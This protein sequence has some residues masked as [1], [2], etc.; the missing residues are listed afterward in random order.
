MKRWPSLVR[1]IVWGVGGLAALI[2]LF[3]GGGVAVLQT[4]SGRRVLAN[5]VNAA[6]SG[7]GLAVSV[8]N[9]GAGLPARIAIGSVVVSDDQGPWVTLDQ[10]VIEWR[11]LTLL[12]GTVHLETIDVA[13]IDL[14]RLPAGSEPEEPAEAVPL[15]SLEI[16]TLPI[17]VRVDRIGMR[18]ITLAEAVAGE[19]MVLDLS[20]RV[21]AQEGKAVR[22]DL[23]LERT[24]AGGLVTLVSELD[25]AEQTL[26]VDFEANE[27]KGGLLARLL[28]LAP[29]PPV[30]VTVKGEGPLDAWRAN[31]DA[32]AEEL[33][34]VTA[35]L[36]VDRDRT[37]AISLEGRADVAGL[38][39]PSVRSLVA[40]GV[41]FSLAAHLKDLDAVTVD[42]LTVETP[43][44]SA[45]GSGQVDV[46]GNGIDATLSVSAPKGD[47]LAPLLSPLRVGGVSAD[48]KVSGALTTPTVNLASTV[49][50]LAVPGVAEAARLEIAA[51]ARLSEDPMAIEAHVD[52]R[53]LS[54]GD[55]AAA[56]L[57]GDAATIA[58]A[59]TYDQ[60]NSVLDIG[61][62]E[63]QSGPTRLSGH[64]RL[65]L[66]TQKVAAA[67]DA[68]VS[69]L[70]ALGAALG[71]PLSG[72][73]ELAAETEGNLETLTLGGSVHG[74]LPRPSVGDAAVDDLLR[75]GVRISGTYSL[76][77]AD[78]ISFDALV[79]AGEL[80]ELRANG[81]ID[82]TI[83]A[84][85]TVKAGNLSAFSRLA[86]T[87]LSGSLSLTAHAEGRVEDAKGTLSAALR[88]ADV[89]GVAIPAADL[90][91]D[92][93]DLMQSPS[94]RLSLEARTGYG[95]VDLRTDFTLAEFARLALRDLTAETLGVRLAGNLQAPLDGG[96]MTGQLRATFEE[97]GAGREI[98]GV[99]VAGRSELDVRLG[100]QAGKQSA[101][102]G[103]DAS[104]LAVSVNGDPAFQA[105]RLSLEARLSD[106]LGTPRGSLTFKGKDAGSAAFLAKTVSGGVDGSLAGADFQARMERAGDPDVRLALVGRHAMNGGA[107]TVTLRQID[108]VVGPYPVKLAGPAT[109]TYAPAEIAVENFSLGVGKGVI[110]ANGRLGGT[111]SAATLRMTGLPLDLIAQFDPTLPL[112]GTIAANAD[113]RAEGEG[114]G[115][116]MAIRGQN[117]AYGGADMEEAPPVDMNVDAAWRGGLVNVDARIVGIGGQDLVATARG[118]LVVDTRTLQASVDER[119]PI[120]ATARWEGQVEPLWELLPLSDMRL[121]GLG[122]I[123]VDVS[124]TLAQPRPSGEVTIKN[125]TFE[126]FV[127]GTL[128]EN[129]DLSATVDKG[130]AIEISLSGTD[131]ESGRISGEG[132]ANLSDL[133]GKPIAITVRFDKA[134]LVRRDDVTAKASGSVSFRGTPAKGRLEGKIVTDRVDVRLVNQLPP[135]VVT[136]DVTEVHAEGDPRS[137]KEESQPAEPSQI[138]LDITVEL[139]RNVHVNG[140]GLESE[141]EGSFHITG[142]TDTPIIEGSLS[143]VRGQFTFAGKRFRLTEG[144]VTLDG[145]KEIEPR[146]NIVA[147]YTSGDFTATIT[148]S[149]PASD[150]KLVLGSNPA[151]P[152]EEILPRILFGKNASQLSAVEAAQLALAVQGLA[153]GGRGLSDTMLSTV[154][155]ALGI[156][157]LSVE[158][159]GE[160]GTDAAV[161]VGKYISDRVYVETVRGTEPGSA[162]VRVEVKIID[163]FAVESSIGQGTDDTSGFIGLKWQYRY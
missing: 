15:D 111:R 40:E 23:R 82:E 148:V 51:E 3:V 106:L 112:S 48:V 29:Y 53:G 11:P 123:A 89:G 24:D 143:I 70:A 18:D 60:G 61:G 161:R 94:G 90:T 87:P 157:V 47:D 45:S 20:G 138:A 9:I 146:L 126:Q 1:W 118:P 113:I 130:Q 14:Q 147:E 153:S 6:L 73:A 55:P 52:G 145:G 154:Q 7:P 50:D 151:M 108:G 134:T 31:L 91:I 84:D 68:R 116:T 27:P 79:E 129:L 99:R 25:P 38:L 64:G 119:A 16:P 132:T 21:A 160:D 83:A 71:I 137:E 115:G 44:V 30:T 37:T 85:A 158:S 88:D 32:R 8:E 114:L 5:A 75:D 117:I 156:D 107:H 69:D 36:A 96:A 103:L 150:P 78:K 58:V 22:T 80:L 163:N 49:R 162:I 110:A 57:T 152:Q 59:A 74:G 54:V 81:R 149:G 26:L 46:A 121:A 95:P 98:A 139:P 125:G 4:E 93:R 122:R 62:L 66:S 92:A 42:R 28:G 35:R 17:A 97:A 120:A 33:A 101:D 63:V 128:I 159:T 140:R 76:D 124:G 131:G 141:W 72:P 135:S 100:D 41:D 102:I 19:A 155:N 109:V 2:A 136:L 127:A 13:G 144:V 104:S 86:G 65:G 12:S 77:G 10:A 105:E 56:A 43:A 67:L 133:G 39:D 142:T 34:H